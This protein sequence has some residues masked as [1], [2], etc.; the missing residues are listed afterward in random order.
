MNNLE[1]YNSLGVCLRKDRHPI[2]A[3]RLRW[4]TTPRTG[5]SLGMSEYEVKWHPSLYFAIIVSLGYDKNTTSVQKEMQK[6]NL[7]PIDS[8]Y[9]ISP[10]ETWQSPGK[11]QS[12]LPPN[13]QTCKNANHY[14]LKFMHQSFETPAPPHSGFSGA[15][16]FYAS[17]SEWSP[18]FPGP[19]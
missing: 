7:T 2:Q 12:F 18:R 14:G 11:F 17:E 9:I 4:F 16:T 10:T 15:F 1:N 6:K 3:H 13:Q 8:E 19:K 5:N